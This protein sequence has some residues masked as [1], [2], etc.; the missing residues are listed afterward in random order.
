VPLRQLAA[1]C[2][3][4]EAVAGAVQPP[5]SGRKASAS[6]A[7]AWRAARK[8]LS[9]LTDGSHTAVTNDRLSCCAARVVEAMDLVPAIGSPDLNAADR[10]A[11]ERAADLL[12]ALANTL[13]REL[14]LMTQPPLGLVTD[15]PLHEGRV[16]DWLHRRSFVATREDIAACRAPVT[17]ARKRSEDFRI[18]F[19]LSL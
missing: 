7:D 19:E 1:V 15:R 8:G 3:A 4:A 5:S 6:A 2:R 17:A 18:P 11:L 12:P 13:D 14:R 9:R 16:N 10:A